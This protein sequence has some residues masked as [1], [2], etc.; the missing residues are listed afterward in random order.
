MHLIIL[1][2]ILEIKSKIQIKGYSYEDREYDYILE[3]NKDFHVRVI[4]E[5][6]ERWSYNDFFQMIII[7][8]WIV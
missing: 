7:P 8:I 2:W 4:V 6:W 5:H 1:F 3:F